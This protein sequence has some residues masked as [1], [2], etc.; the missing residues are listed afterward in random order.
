MRKIASPP[1]NPNNRKWWERDFLANDAE[2]LQSKHHIGTDCYN[3]LT[4]A[5]KPKNVTTVSEWLRGGWPEGVEM[6]HRELGHI[7]LPEMTDIRRRVHWASEGDTLNVERLYGGDMERCWGQYSRGTVRRP[8]P[9]HIFCDIS[10]NCGSEAL[11]WRGATQFAFVEAAVAA[12]HR[13]A[14]EQVIN[15]EG[16]TASGSGF[17]AVT[18]VK[19]FDGA[20]NPSALAA[21]SSNTASMRLT[22]FGHCTHVPENI[23]CYGG[24]CSLDMSRIT[25]RG[26]VDP[27]AHTLLVPNRIQNKTMAQEWLR[28]ACDDLHQRIHTGD[29]EARSES[30]LVSPAR[31]EWEV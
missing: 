29:W 22:D 21:I 17:L 25:S 2:M 26:L 12:G 27:R 11:F 16:L 3:A 18:R 20:F 10:V 28:T 30:G 19:D 14:V 1:I 8:P 31:A 6:I 9:I 15:I 4:K 7:E 5:R 23:H 24:V 13:V